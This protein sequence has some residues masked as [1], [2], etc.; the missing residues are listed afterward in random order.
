MLVPFKYDR[1]LM[2]TVLTKLII[3]AVALVYCGMI[4]GIKY[5]DIFERHHSL[6]SSLFKLS[7]FNI[8]LASIDSPHSLF[9]VILM[10]TD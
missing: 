10:D 7:V 6:I 1:G 2:T 9:F 8:K 5:R 4:F 3:V